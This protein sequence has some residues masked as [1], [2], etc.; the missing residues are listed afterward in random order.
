MHP[1][2]PIEFNEISQVCGFSSCRLCM[3]EIHNMYFNV[4]EPS[5]VSSVEMLTD[6]THCLVAANVIEM[7]L[8]TVHQS[9]LG[10]PYILYTATFAGNTINQVR[11]LACYLMFRDICSIGVCTE[12]P[13]TLVEFWGSNGIS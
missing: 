7:G 1:L 4:L 8:K 6:L 5:V 9:V 13:P 10:L 2:N 3:D 11:T 12:N